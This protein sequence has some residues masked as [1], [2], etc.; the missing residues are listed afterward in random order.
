MGLVDEYYK[1]VWY[2]AFLIFII[3]AI[4]LLQ[5]LYMDNY[6]PGMRRKMIEDAFPDGIYN[7]FES[8]YGEKEMMRYADANGYKRNFGTI[9]FVGSYSNIHIDDALIENAPQIWEDDPTYYCECILFAYDI[10]IG[11]PLYPLEEMRIHQKGIFE[12]IFHKEKNEVRYPCITRRSDYII[13]NV[14]RIRCT[15]I[16]MEKFG[17]QR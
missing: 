2:I 13:R 7:P 8:T 3:V 14:S 11:S 15:L 12:R 16:E 17:N 5:K 4:R 9:S 6:I 1:F 10:P